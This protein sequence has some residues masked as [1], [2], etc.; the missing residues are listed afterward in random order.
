[1]SKQNNHIENYLN[2]FSQDKN[3]FYVPDNYFDSIEETV[4]SS[5]VEDQLPGGL[6]YNVPSDYFN[7]VEKSILD[8][9]ELKE[10]KV[11]VISLKNRLLKIIPTA[12]AACIILFVGFNYINISNSN[13]IESITND[14]I[15][16]WINENF[17]EYSSTHSIEFVDT[18]FTEGDIMVEDSSLNDDDILDYLNSIDNSSLLT[19]IES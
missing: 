17:N 3:K 8:K 16:L 12:A 14:E 13:G 11:K 19:E 15:E 18:D 7:S 2:N 10:Q 4:L 5:V 6:S 1:M 9:L